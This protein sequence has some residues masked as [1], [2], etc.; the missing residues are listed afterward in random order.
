MVT[1]VPGQRRE[2]APQ[3]G[4]Q[5]GARPARFSQADVDLRRLDALHVLVQFG[6][7]GSSRRRDHFGL[8]EEDLLDAPADLVGFRQ[9]RAGQ[10][11]RLDGE[12]ALVELRQERRAHARDRAI[13]ASQQR[14]RDD[15]HGARM[16]ERARQIAGEARLERPR[17]PPLVP[18]QDRS[19]ARQ[20]RHS[21]APA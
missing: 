15:H 5:F 10:R 1:L 3:I 4:E 21:T 2:A 9:R 6:A 11:V 13:A 7:A 18:P 20:E 19:R 8:G 14:Q 12:A 17:Q 16:V